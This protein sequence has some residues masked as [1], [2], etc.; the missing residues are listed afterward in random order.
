MNTI[1]KIILSIVFLLVACDAPID[2]PTTKFKDT[3]GARKMLADFAKQQHRFE[4]SGCDQIYNDKKFNPNMTLKK[5]EGIF[6]PYTN[7]EEA[8]GYKNNAYF[9]FNGA[10]R[11]LE[12]NKEKTIS[13]IGVRFR[14]ISPK[15]S[16][17]Y[18][19]VDGAPLNNNMTMGDFIN[20]SH[21]DF[22]DFNISSRSYKIAYRKCVH[23]IQYHLSSK[24]NFS[25]I[26]N[27]HMR[28]KDK[29]NFETTFPVSSFEIYPY[30]N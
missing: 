14:E 17:F 28:L 10:M 19:L 20:N 22:V 4:F 27:G 25:Y 7:K 23:P 24:V 11:V 26:G 3:P 2:I 6:G 21:F 8:N 18:I 15:E 1:K 5:L 16:P 12:N 13:A 9:W 30:Q 29:P